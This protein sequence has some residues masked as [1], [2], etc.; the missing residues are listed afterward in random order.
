MSY[1]VQVISTVVQ[2]I[3]KLNSSV[4]Q[5]MVMKMEELAINPLPEGVRKLEEK[6]PLYLVRVD[7]YRIVYQ[8]QEEPSLITVTKIA[9]LKDY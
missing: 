6:K 7:D 2:Q 4:Q 8:V 9:H 5:Q 1:Q 3:E